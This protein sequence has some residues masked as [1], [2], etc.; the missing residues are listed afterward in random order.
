MGPSTVEAIKWVY[1]SLRLCENRRQ[2]ITLLARF[3]VIRN[4]HLKNWYKSC[5]KSS[6]GLEIQGDFF[7]WA[8]PDNVSRLAPPK[9]A[10]PCAALRSR[11]GAKGCWSHFFKNPT[12]QLRVV[13]VLTE[14]K[15]EQT[16]KFACF[17]V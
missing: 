11:L 6:M 2:L 15:C 7:N 3:V 4:A 12:T 10:H 14:K 1:P 8:S 13:W 17:R 16:P 9:G 5:L